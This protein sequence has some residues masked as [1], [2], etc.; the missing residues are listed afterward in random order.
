MQDSKLLSAFLFVAGGLGIAV[1]LALVFVPVAFQAS[2]GIDLG[3]DVNL[4]NETRAPG[5]ALLVVASL[6]F[7]G[8]FVPRLR[9]TATLLAGTVYLAYGAGRLLS[10]ALDGMPSA[11]LIQVM[12]LEVAL[13]AVGMLALA[14]YRRRGPDTVLG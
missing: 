11:V 1:G 7:A 10:I 12:V 5:S 6:V 8:A 13:G 14:R 3:G 2:N 4:I 9:F